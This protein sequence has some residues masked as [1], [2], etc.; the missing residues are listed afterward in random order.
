LE[1]KAKYIKEKPYVIETDFFPHDG[2]NHD[3]LKGQS[4]KNLAIQ[5]GLRPKVL[6]KG[7]VLERIEYTKANFSRVRINRANCQTLIKDLIGYRQRYDA[8][9]V[10]Y[11]GLPV[12][13]NS[14]HY[15]DCFGLMMLSLKYINTPECNYQKI[16]EAYYRNNYSRHSNYGGSFGK[17]KFDHA[18]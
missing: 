1:Q 2:A 10:R 13:D 5:L 16:E 15:A 11:T 4:I 3:Q 17:R 7:S 6:P 8:S 12:K 9:N 18:I 14:C